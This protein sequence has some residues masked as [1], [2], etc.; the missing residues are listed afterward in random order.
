MRR[1]RA[2]GLFGRGRSFTDEEVEI[3][4]ESAAGQHVDQMLT[5]SAVG[6]PAEVGD[7]LADFAKRADADEL[8]VAH[9]SPTTEQRLRSVELTASALESAPV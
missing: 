7:F 8:I 5:Y 3:L 9:Q 1:I 2:V 6:T 4:L